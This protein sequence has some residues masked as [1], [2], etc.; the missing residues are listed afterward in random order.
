V[1]LNNH[2]IG[3]GESRGIYAVSFM[4]ENAIAFF[5]SQTRSHH[6]NKSGGKIFKRDRITNQPKRR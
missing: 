3:T 1:E 5:C 4:D 6:Q 2:E